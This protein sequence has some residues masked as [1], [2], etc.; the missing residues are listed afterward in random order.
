MKNM[1]LI[2]GITTVLMAT[3][4]VWVDNALAKRLEQSSLPEKTGQAQRSERIVPAV[5]LPENT[6]RSM[7]NDT[8]AAMT[9]AMAGAKRRCTGV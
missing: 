3:F 8:S 5:G 6:I 2:A 7:P 9:P 4:L 1:L